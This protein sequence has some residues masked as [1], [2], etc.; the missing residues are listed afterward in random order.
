MNSVPQNLWDRIPQMSTGDVMTLLLIVIVAV[1]VAI[2][3][4]GSII[5]AMHKNRLED[6]LK[7]ELLDRGMNA[8]EIATVIRAKTGTKASRR[9]A[10]PE[11]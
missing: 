5:Y 8:D 4:I 6:S 1:L 10:R 7:R 2:T 11:F 9:P 3:I